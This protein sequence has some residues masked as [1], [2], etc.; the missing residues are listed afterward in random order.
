MAGRTFA[1]EASFENSNVYKFTY[2]VKI[3]RTALRLLTGAALSG[4]QCQ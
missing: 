1:S 4:H 3:L 2:Y